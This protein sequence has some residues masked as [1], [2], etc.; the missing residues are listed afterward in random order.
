MARLGR[1]GSTS[2]EFDGAPALGARGVT[3]CL[4]ERP[5]EFVVLTFAAFDSS[6]AL[7]CGDC[8]VATLSEI[9]VANSDDIKKTVMPTNAEL[10]GRSKPGMWINVGIVCHHSEEFGLLLNWPP[11]GSQW[12][13]IHNRPAQTLAN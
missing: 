13:R 8:E 6:E 12:P 3:F 9:R 7:R 5:G 1:T 10:R 11:F 4:R 2:P